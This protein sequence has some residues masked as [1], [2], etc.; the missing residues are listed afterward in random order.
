[1][2]FAR[3]GVVEGDSEGTKD[4]VWSDGRSTG[5]FDD[6]SRGEG[7]AFRVGVFGLESRSRKLL[8]LKGDE[9]DIRKVNRKEVNN[10]K[11]ETTTNLIQFGNQ[12]AQFI[13]S[14]V[15]IRSR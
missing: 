8:A 10:A 13:H 11:K 4:G 12:S 1:M 5:K 7:G 2:T 14:H 15:P 6:N 9:D 3:I